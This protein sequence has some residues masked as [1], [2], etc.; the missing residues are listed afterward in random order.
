[1]VPRNGAPPLRVVDTPG[2]MI[3]AVGLANPGVVAVRA[4]RSPWLAANVSR[5]RVIVNVVGDTVEDYRVA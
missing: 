2:G 1:M 4:R 5:A 3:N